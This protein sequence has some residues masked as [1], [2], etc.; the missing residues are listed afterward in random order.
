MEVQIEHRPGRSSVVHI[1]PA[2][3]DDLTALTDSLALAENAGQ[4]ALTWVHGAS[5]ARDEV[6]LETGR[7]SSRTLLQ[8]RRPLPAEPSDLTTRAFTDDDLDDFIRVNNRAFAWHPEQGGL[9]ADR[10]QADMKAPWFDPDGF[11]LLHIDGTLAGFCWTKVYA[12]PEP[13]VPKAQERGRD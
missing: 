7:Q 2:E 10:V 6:M 4:D 5:Q 13:P 8:M 11:R 12:E 1:T 9:D 3:S